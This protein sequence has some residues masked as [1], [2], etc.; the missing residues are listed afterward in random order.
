VRRKREWCREREQIAQTRR[1]HSP[2]LPPSSPPTPP[3]ETQGSFVHWSHKGAC[4]VVVLV[5][6]L[7]VVASLPPQGI[8]ARPLAQQSYFVTDRGSSAPCRGGD[9]PPVYVRE[10]EREREREKRERLCVCACACVC[11]RACVRACVRV[12]V[13][14]CVCV[15]YRKTSAGSRSS[16]PCASDI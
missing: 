6:V 14:V 4:P 9:A 1:A 8:H 16:I 11:V 7:V 2:S 10:R 12:C 15:T 3:Q 5:V 13:C